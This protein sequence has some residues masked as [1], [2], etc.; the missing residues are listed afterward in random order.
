MP[1]D[2]D[3][4]TVFALYKLFATPQEQAQMRE[5]YLAGGYGYGAAK[6][7]LFERLMHF[8]APMRAKREELERNRHYVERVL[9]DGAQRARSVAIEKIK[10]VKK[11]TGLVGNIY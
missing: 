9:R 1:K 11:V 8:F 10:K 2:P 3:K 6:K 7:E 4:C 5:Q